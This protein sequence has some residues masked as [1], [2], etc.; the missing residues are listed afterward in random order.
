MKRRPG[1]QPGEQHWKAK[2][3][4]EQVRQL[5]QDHDNDLGGY[6][7]LAKK[8]GI[9]MSTARDIVNGYTRRSALVRVPANIGVDNVC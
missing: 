6:R 5:R 7:T 2:L 9:G 3:T 1:A 8:Y 4:D